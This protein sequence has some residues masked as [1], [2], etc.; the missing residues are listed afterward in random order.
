MREVIHTVT[1]WSGG[2]TLTGAATGQL[3]IAAI[4]LVFMIGFGAFGSW[5]R[6]RDSKALRAALDSGDLATAMKIRSK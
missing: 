2:V 5:L 4:G 3:M 1:S 6:Y